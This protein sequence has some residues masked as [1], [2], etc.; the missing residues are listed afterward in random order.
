MFGISIQNI[1][2]RLLVVSTAG[3]GQFLAPATPSAI[4]M[5]PVG[6]AWERR[7]LRYMQCRWNDQASS[8]WCGQQDHYGE[9]LDEQRRIVA[10]LSSD[11]L[12]RETIQQ[13]DQF[14][15]LYK[16]VDTLAGA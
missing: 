11:E 15:G 16:L 1:E 3:T 2:N 14:T 8:W 7:T 13:A 10:S 9:C 12:A 5:G 6:L 4:P